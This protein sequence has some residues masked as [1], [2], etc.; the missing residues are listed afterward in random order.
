[1][2]PDQSYMS[3]CGFTICGLVEQGTSTLLVCY[4]R[5]LDF[6]GNNDPCNKSDLSRNSS[7]EYVNIVLR[8]RTP[9]ACEV[10]VNMT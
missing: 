2:E 1:M 6:M 8:R 10:L 9:R 7:L 5:F 4:L 3:I